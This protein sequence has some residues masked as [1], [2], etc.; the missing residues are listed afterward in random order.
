MEEGWG[1]VGE[2]GGYI[3]VRSPAQR[4][5]NIYRCGEPSAP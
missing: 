1:W 5:A 4:Q 2:G 3:A